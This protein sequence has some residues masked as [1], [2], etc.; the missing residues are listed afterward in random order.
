MSDPDPCREKPRQ[1]ISSLMPRRARWIASLLLLLS[2][3]TLTQGCLLGLEASAKLTIRHDFR[4]EHKCPAGLEE[5]VVQVN[6]IAQTALACEGA[7]VSHSTGIMVRDLLPGTH[8]I[9][10][11]GIDIYGEVGWQSKKRTVSVG[12]MQNK[13]IFLTLEPIQ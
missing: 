11:Q 12:A 13:E 2:L 7:S 1:K 8:N 5:I 10:V 9:V 4:G 3:G 6:G